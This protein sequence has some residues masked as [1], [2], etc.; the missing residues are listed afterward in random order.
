MKTPC[1]SPRMARW[2]TAVAGSLVLGGLS[3][4]LARHAS[5]DGVPDT[6]LVYAGYLEDA[7]GNPANG[8]LPLV[9]GIFDAASGGAALCTTLT[10][11]TATRGWFSVTLDPSCTDTVRGGPNRW[12]ELTIQG[13][14]LPRQRIGA[15][16]YAHEAG[17]AAGATGKLATTLTDLAAQITA[18]KTAADGTAAKLGGGKMFAKGGNNGTV[19]CATYCEGSKW[20]ETGSCV[21]ARR[22]SDKTYVSCD[23]VLTTTSAECFCLSFLARSEQGDIVCLVDD[24]ASA[25]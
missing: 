12:I 24:I 23:T 10:T 7:A 14:V 5:A 4:G 1:L 19:S 17:R 15:V 8:P 3:F 25:L 13:S 18:S 22:A 6:P 21:A 16:P 11:L 2:G 9:A 20:G